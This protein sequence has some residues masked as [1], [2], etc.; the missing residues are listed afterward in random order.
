MVGVEPRVSHRLG[1]H[2]IPE[3]QPQ[4]KDFAQEAGTSVSCLEMQHTSKRE[5]GV[6]A[7]SSP[8]QCRSVAFPLAR[9]VSVLRSPA[10]PE[11]DQPAGAG[12]GKPNSS[13][14]LFKGQSQASLW[15]TAFCNPVY[16]IKSTRAGLASFLARSLTTL[17]GIRQTQLDLYF[18]GVIW[19]C[20]IP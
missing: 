10:H 13:G 14:C 15:L 12:G 6:S 20:I 17:F 18:L 1:K 19:R 5:T 7:S 16:F 11:R 2:S 4:P 3:Y 9:E 8:Q